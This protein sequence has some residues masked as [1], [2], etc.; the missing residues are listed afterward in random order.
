MHQ[1]DVTGLDD[2]FDREVEASLSLREWGQFLS[3]AFSALGNVTRLVQEDRFRVIDAQHRLQIAFG[4]GVLEEAADFMGTLRRH[5][6][7]S[8][9]RSA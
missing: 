2:L 8:L 9:V 7:S 5:G 4:H 1:Y 3:Q 6:L